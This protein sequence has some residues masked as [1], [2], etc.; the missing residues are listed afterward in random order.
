MTAVKKLVEKKNR[1]IHFIT[2]TEKL[3]PVIWNITEIPELYK[4][5]QQ[6]Q[7]VSFTNKNSMTSSHTYLLASNGVNLVCTTVEYRIVCVHLLILPL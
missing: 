7:G 6:R 4:D 3:L 2:E 1:K 5:S